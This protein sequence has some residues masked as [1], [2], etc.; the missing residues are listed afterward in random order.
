MLQ[1]RIGRRFQRL[2]NESNFQSESF[3]LCS[4][5]ASYD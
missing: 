5:A 1:I 2:G 4:G 3:F